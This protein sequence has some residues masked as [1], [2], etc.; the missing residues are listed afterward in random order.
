MIPG[1]THFFQSLLVC[2]D[3]HSWYSTLKGL[4]VCVFV[5]RCMFTTQPQVSVVA[6]C[7]ETGLFLLFLAIANAR[8]ASMNSQILS[9][10][11]IW[12]VRTLGT[13][14]HFLWFL[15]ML[16]QVPTSMA[17]IYQAISPDLKGLLTPTFE[18]PNLTELS[19]VN[20]GQVAPKSRREGRRGKA[21]GKSFRSEGDRP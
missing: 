8:L 1:P 16:T 9:L 7:L 10:L 2:I 4:L 11:P 5:H 14:N 18:F 19:Q 13:W 12:P 15:R 3:V 17:F 6:F 20:G 21:S